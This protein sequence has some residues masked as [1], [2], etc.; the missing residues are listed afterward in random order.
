MT[1]NRLSPT[2]TLALSLLACVAFAWGCS[3]SKGP[4]PG[5]SS[6]QTSGGFS[7]GSDEFGGD[8]SMQGNTTTDPQLEAL[9]TIYFDY[10]RAV[11][12]GDQK[13]A[14]ESSAV[15]IGNN[16]SWGTIVV[17]GHCDERGSEEYNLA[18]GERRAT[19]VKRYLSDLGVPAQRLDVVSFGESKPAVQG[20]DE[21]AWRWNRRAEF[22]QL[23]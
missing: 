1:R 22:R 17:E 5:S 13:S 7:S 14:L 15:A 23:N 21:S 16:A 6:G 4:A 2:T 11:V 12:R 20:H 9:Q 18:L 10:D 3:S 8:G 19:A